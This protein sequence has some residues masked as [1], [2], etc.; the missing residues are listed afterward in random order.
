MVHFL[1]VIVCRSGEFLPNC[2]ACLTFNQ[3]TPKSNITPRRRLF[4]ALEWPSVVFITLTRPDSWVFRS[5]LRASRKT[6]A[7]DYC[8]LDVCYWRAIKVDL[9]HFPWIKDIHKL[10]ARRVF[11]NTTNCIESNQAFVT[12]CTVTKPYPRSDII[13]CW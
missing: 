11:S 10:L 12:K 3:I 7:H 6:M 2:Y 9:Y 13:L 4:G 5:R 8:S 1:V